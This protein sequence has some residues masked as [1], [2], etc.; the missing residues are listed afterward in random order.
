ME[1]ARVQQPGEQH[2]DGD[3]G[4]AEAQ[5]ARTE[6]RQRVHDDLL[7]LRRAQGWHVS[8]VAVSDAGSGEGR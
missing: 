3:L 4:K 8:A 2:D 7:L 1:L 5:H 6:A